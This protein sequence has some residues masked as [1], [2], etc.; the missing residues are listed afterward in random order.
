[1]A[2]VFNLGGLRELRPGSGG[3]GG[4]R[5]GVGWDGGGGGRCVFLLVSPTGN[6]L[7]AN[8]SVAISITQSALRR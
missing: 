4:G 5:G 3:G 2:Q 6:I 7:H 1:M 8:V